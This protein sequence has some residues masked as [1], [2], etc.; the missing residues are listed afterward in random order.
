MKK[1]LAILATLAIATIGYSQS[2]STFVTRSQTYAVALVPV[3]TI[4]HKGNLTASLDSLVGVNL[5]SPAGAFG[6]SL[7][8]TY[9]TGKGWNF[10]LGIG[11]AEPVS[12]V[13]FNQFNS[14]YLHNHA[15]LTLG[16]S[17]PFNISSLWSSKV[18]TANTEAHSL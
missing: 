17:A 7:D 15:G 5:S 9:S 14:V 3:K 16:I 2:A 11:L 6:C 8:G 18:T 1:T 13:N 12:T 10:V 4:Y